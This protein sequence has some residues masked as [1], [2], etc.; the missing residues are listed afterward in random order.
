LI[1]RDHGE[2]FL[3]LWSRHPNRTDLHGMKAKQHLS[4]SESAIHAMESTV[5]LLY[6]QTKKR[7]GFQ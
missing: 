3:R 4:Q 1:H 2:S 7:E 6:L 5:S